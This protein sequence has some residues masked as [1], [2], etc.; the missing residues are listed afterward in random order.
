[1][2]EGTL[3]LREKALEIKLP[4][5]VSYGGRGSGM[6]H[7]GSTKIKYIF[8]KEDVAARLTQT[9]LNTS[10]QWSKISLVCFRKAR[11]KEG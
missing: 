8:Q 9:A 1:M 11:G 7:P 3:S 5:P 6:T 4:E 2:K 10:R